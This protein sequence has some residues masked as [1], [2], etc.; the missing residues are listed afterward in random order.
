MMMTG[1]KWLIKIIKC[2][3]C[4]A[5][6]AGPLFSHCICDICEAGTRGTS[7]RII[8]TVIAMAPEGVIEQFITLLT[9]TFV[10][11]L[12]PLFASSN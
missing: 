9:N 2:K 12:L 5:Q 11:I 10:P 8:Y 6:I 4:M 7:G 1:K 3:S